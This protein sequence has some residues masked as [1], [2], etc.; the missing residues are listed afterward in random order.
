MKPATAP[1]WPGAAG[2]DASTTHACAGTAQ[3]ATATAGWRGA[4]RRWRPVVLGLFS[5]LMLGFVIWRLQALDWAAAWRAA[6][7]LPA[8]TLALAAVIAVVGHLNY[9]AFDLLA[10]RWLRLDIAR[11]R[12][13][14]IGSVSYAF[15]MNF[16]SVIGGAAVRWRLLAAQGLQGADVT[17]V[18][19]LAVL[20]NWLGYALVTGVLL[21]TWGPSLRTPPPAAARAGELT[22]GMGSQS[23]QH[24][25]DQLHAALSSPVTQIAATALLLVVLAWL[26]LLAGLRQPPARVRAAGLQPAARWLPPAQV[27]LGAANWLWMAGVMACLLHGAGH[28]D[29]AFT[30]VLAAQVLASL[31][32]LLAR[33]P[34]G[35]GVFEAVY[36]VMLGQQVDTATLLGALLVFRALYFL[37]PLLVALPGYW[38][39]T[40]LPARQA[41]ALDQPAEAP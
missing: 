5:V 33:V 36:W 4:W 26:V 15:T 40:R 38:M 1:A 22:D 16:G 13:A 31:A 25:A 10:R 12:M 41:G 37:L 20:T 6:R 9:S 3:R 17:R 27:A 24:Y 32:G 30:R 28:D 35:L 14:W 21:L 34:G 18:V 7:A 39:L 2:S 23:L 11:W 29:V 8:T 19:T